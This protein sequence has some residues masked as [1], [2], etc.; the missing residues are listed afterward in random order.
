MSVLKIFSENDIS[1]G[2]ECPQCG[3]VLNIHKTNM[4]KSGDGFVLHPQ[5]TCPCKQTYGSIAHSR[6]N[7][8]IDDRNGKEYNTVNIGNQ[9]WL[10]ENLAYKAD[11][12][13]WA[14]SILTKTGYFYTWATAKHICPKGWH[15]PSKEE[16]EMLLQ[17]FVGKYGGDGEKI[18]DALSSVGMSSFNARKTSYRRSCDRF[19]ELNS[20]AGFWSSSPYDG[21]HVWSLIMRTERQDDDYNVVKP[22]SA[23][24]LDMSMD[25]GFSVRCLRD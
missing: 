1:I 3:R 16:F 18:F 19:L 6:D 22:A 11:S 14:S 15:L 21:N 25:Y 8:F 4:I 10:A 5:V 17:N 2:V 20:Y 24:M 12:G 7:I 9:I 13:C 23:T